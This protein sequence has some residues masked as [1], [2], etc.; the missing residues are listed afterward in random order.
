MSG[1]CVKNTSPTVRSGKVTA[2]LYQLSSFVPP[3]KILSV[4]IVVSLLYGKASHYASFQQKFD[5]K[6]VN[7]FAALQF[8]FNRNKFVNCSQ[9]SF[10]TQKCLRRLGLR[11]TL[12]KMHVKGINPGVES[13][14]PG[15][16]E[17]LIRP[18]NSSIE[19]QKI[20]AHVLPNITG[21]Q[22]S[23]PVDI[24]RWKHIS[25][26]NLADPDFNS[27]HRVEMLLGGDVYATL[28]RPGVLLGTNP[29]EPAAINT[30]FGWVINGPVDFRVPS[31]VNTYCT[32]MEPEPL[33]VSLKRLW[34]LEEVPNESFANPDDIQC[35]RLYA[36]SVTRGEN[37]R[38]TVALP[39]KMQKTEFPNSRD[40]AVRRFLLLE[41]RLIRNP[42]LQQEYVQFMRDYLDSNHMSRAPPLPENSVQNYYIPHHCILRPDSSST[43]LRVVFD[44]SAKASNGQSLNDT[45]YSGPKLL[46]D[47]VKVLLKFRLHR[48]VFTADI[49]Q[50]YRQ[51]LISPKDRDF[52]RIIWRSSPDDA[53]E[54]YVLNT[55]TYGISSA[56]FL[57]IRT[58][59][60]L[61]DD[62][63]GRFPGAAEILRTDVYM[64]DIVTGCH[65]TAEALELQDQLIKLLQI[66]QFELRKWASNS[67]LVVDHLD[68]NLRQVT[69]EFD[70]NKS[71]SLIKILGLQWLPSPD[72]FSFKVNLKD[73]ACTKRNISSEVARIF[74]PLGFL[75]PLTFFAK[76]LIQ[77]LWCLGLS[78]DDVPPQEVIDR[79]GQ[80]LAQLPEVSEIKINRHLSI[81]SQLSCELHG[82][83]DASEIGF[84][85]AVYLRVTTADNEVSVNLVM[86]KTPLKRR[87]LPQLELCGA[88]LLSKLIKYVRSIYESVCSFASV[89][90]WTDSMI[91]L[92]W[93]RSSPHRW[94]T[95]VSNRVAYIQEKISPASWRY[96]RS[97]DNPADCASRGL[98]PA[99]LKIHPLWWNGPTWLCQQPDNW[100][101]EPSTAPPTALT[102]GHFLTLAPLTCLPEP[103]LEHVKLN[104]LS[105]WQLLQRMHQSFWDRWH[106]EYLHTLQQ[107]SKWHKPQTD[108]SRGTLVLI[109]NDQVPPL[110]WNLGRVE[111][112]H[113]GADGVIRVAIVKTNGGSFRRPVVKLCP[114]PSQ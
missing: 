111:D 50:M 88:Q 55:V 15:F 71:N 48:V 100:P 12:S 43:K 20:I 30:I 69:L 81:G 54:E 103:N 31:V 22:P 5:S 75:A 7:N 47:I 27:S 91:V 106:R 77:H 96:I 11:F 114:L 38:Y 72:T 17:C 67:S 104:R 58:L 102:P 113:P 23:N 56:P 57:A 86:A 39:F 97:S 109:K 18:R 74:D 59:L 68:P 46:Q 62:E 83:C 95:F 33:E 9:G 10:I 61:A 80:Y 52:Q 78:W 76:H 70:Q 36:A 110:Q 49:R 1:L 8:K 51:I 94:K 65:S 53:L 105:R 28:L 63:Q 73:H 84:A 85:A 14:S 32:I 35:E 2:P 13:I 66:G 64:D 45:L 4:E 101:I 3:I 26:L 42:A 98:L 21:D 16:S 107:R 37:G 19:Q 112:I 60:Q 34:E 40:I 44:A 25:N 87:S 82:F 92:G 79:W 99:E 108:L 24:S 90:A 41:N 89:T 93:L 6:F 29:G